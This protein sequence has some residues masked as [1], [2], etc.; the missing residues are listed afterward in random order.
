MNSI[1]TILNSNLA[2]FSVTL[3]GII[4]SCLIT[5]FIIRRAKKRALSRMK[6]YDEIEKMNNGNIK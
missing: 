4:L 5:I 2:L 1:F 3:F 6:E